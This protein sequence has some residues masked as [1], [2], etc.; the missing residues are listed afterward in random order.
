[1][2]GQDLHSVVFVGEAT[3]GDGSPLAVNDYGFSFP[4]PPLGHQ[5]GT[6]LGGGAVVANSKV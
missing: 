3:G 2:S 6:I 4:P 1:M 5:S